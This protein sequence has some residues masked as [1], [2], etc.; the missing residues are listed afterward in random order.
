M[1]YFCAAIWR[2]SV[3]LLRFSFLSNVQ[4]FSCEISLVCPIKYPYSCFSSHFYFLVT[5]ILIMLV[6]FALFL[7][8]VIGFF[9]LFKVVFESLC[10]YIDTIFYA[11]ESSFLFL[12]W[13]LYSVYV[14]LIPIVS[15]SSLRMKCLMYRHYFSCPLNHLLKFFPRSLQ[16]WSWVFYEGDK[17][18]VYYL[19]MGLLYSLISSSFVI[20]PRYSILTFFFLLYL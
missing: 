14:I 7:V 18:G 8:T 4:V 16:E 1:V 3:S 20:Y 9:A 10:C 2:H 12:S 6:L 15:L 5:V 17:P 13:Y 11:G 19:M